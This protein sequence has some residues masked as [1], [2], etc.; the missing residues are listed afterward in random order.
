MEEGY[1]RVLFTGLSIGDKFSTFQDFEKKIKMQRTFS[2]GLE[3]QE[4]WRVRKRD[5][6]G[7]FQ[8]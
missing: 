7:E 8:K 6:L 3:I 4:P 5:I 2:S 1:N